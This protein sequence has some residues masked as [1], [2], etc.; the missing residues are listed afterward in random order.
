M[1]DTSSGDEGTQ[2]RGEWAKWIARLLPVIYFIEDMRRV[3]LK[4]T[5]T[6]DIVREFGIMA[7]TGPP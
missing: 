3:V 7:S 4:G 1:P 5:E 6:K 2:F